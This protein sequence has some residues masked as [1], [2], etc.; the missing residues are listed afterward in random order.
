MYVVR[1]QSGNQVFTL[2]DT[3]SDRTANKLKSGSITQEINSIDTFTFEIYQNNPAFDK[4]HSYSTLVEVYNTKRKRV[5]FKGRVLIDKTHMENTGLIYKEV[6]CESCL[7]YLCD[8]QQPYKITQNW[9]LN[10]LLTEIITNH[11]SQVE[12][13]KKFTLG[14]ITMTAPNDNIFI[15]IQREDTWTTL[16]KK[17]I[18]K[19]GGEFSYRDT[20][21]GLYLDYSPQ[22][23]STKTTTIELAKNMQS[24]TRENDPTSFVTRLIPLGAK[25]QHEDEG[26]EEQE[27]AEISEEARVGIESVNEGKPYID[28]VNAIA[29]YGIIVK[30][31]TWDDVTEPL[32]LLSKAREYL[33]ENNKVLQKYTVTALDLSLIGLDIDDFA[34]GNYYPVKNSLVG[35]D[36]NLRIIKKTIDLIDFQSSK[37]DIGDSQKTLSDIQIGN[38][39][40]I[41]DELGSVVSDWE[42]SVPQIIEEKI[43]SSSIIQQLPDTI[44]SQVEENYTSKSETEELRENMST[45][46]TQTA[47]SWTYE[48][49]KIV[50]QVTAIDGIMDSNFDEIVKYIR[51]VDGNIIL[52]QVNN[53]MTLKIQN[54]RISFMQNGAEVAYMTNNRLYITD[55]E[56]LNSLTLG[57]F[58]FMPRKNGNLSFKKVR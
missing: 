47:Q 3:Y 55:G 19:I 1:I 38:D 11:N 18:E 34:V 25:I 42:N 23:G 17:L 5:E 22:I 41:R 45:Q 24:V 49:N 57:N 8:S 2:H 48:F 33:A 21:S 32:N 12:D 56:F 54:D 29:A 26:A 40:S 44:L 31:Q 58:A 52:G 6:T 39:S 7:G 15:G 46:L 37:F 35:I 36:E 16:T 50:E 9:T 4:I 43:S 10:G 27:E 20:D 51:F 30:Y 28:D 13:Y 53:E 14:N